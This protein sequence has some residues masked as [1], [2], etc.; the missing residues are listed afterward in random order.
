M[1]QYVLS[2]RYRIETNDR[3]I[4]VPNF[5]IDGGGRK[6]TFGKQIH[7]NGR[8]EGLVHI[9]PVVECPTSLDIS[10]EDEKIRFD[11]TDLVNA[12]WSP[13]VLKRMKMKGQIKD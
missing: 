1:R 12:N 6:L 4:G 8:Q 9:E 3:N 5:A 7:F 13:E 2:F 11:M 10:V